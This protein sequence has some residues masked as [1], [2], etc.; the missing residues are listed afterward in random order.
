MRGAVRDRSQRFDFVR[1]LQLFPDRAAA[2]R[3]HDLAAAI[4]VIYL[5]INTDIC[6]HNCPF[7]DGFY[8]SLRAEFLPWPRL[9]TLV[10]EMEDLGVLAVVLAGDRGEP[11]LHPDIEK[12]LSRLARSPVRFAIYTNGTCIGADAWPAL[13]R[14]AFVRVSADAATARTHR[15]MH[16][17]PSGRADY[18]TLIANVERLS[19]LGSDIGIS[20]VLEPRNHTEIASAADCFLSL[21]AHFIEYKPRYLPGYEVDAIWLRS[22]A[23]VIAA[24]IAAARRRWGE[25]V[26]VNNQIERIVFSDGRASPLHTA[27]RPCRTS[28][29]RLVI[30]THGCYT[31]T[32]YRGEPERRV[33]DI[34]EQ[35]LLAVVESAARRALIDRA[36][37]RVCAYHDQNEALLAE[38]GGV[39]VCAPTLDSMRPQDYFI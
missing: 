24:Q 2:A 6:N 37:D 16:A 27:P 4:S 21:G 18:V 10:A 1:K 8:R 11:F 5:D 9:E 36:C 13:S 28:L 23:A 7:C 20:F 15:A 19:R 12:L 29:L 39:A 31:C 25:R 22:A 14:A 32:P 3:R 30:S 33:G 35:P 34:Q 17:Y 38:D 26:V